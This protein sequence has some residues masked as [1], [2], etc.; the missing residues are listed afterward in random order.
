MGH[1]DFYL[2]LKYMPVFRLK[3]F[4]SRIYIA[5]TWIKMIAVKFSSYFNKC[6]FHFL[7]LGFLDASA[8]SGYVAVLQRQE[9]FL[10]LL[11][12]RIFN[13]ADEVQ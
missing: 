12:E 3:K 5:S 13:G 4:N 2:N 8:L 6:F 1:A 11:A 10:C 7:L 9:A